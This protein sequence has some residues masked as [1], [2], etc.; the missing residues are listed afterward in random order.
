MS[1]GR[2]DEALAAANRGLDIDRELGRDREVAAGLG[3]C[4]Q[5]L[6]QQGRHA[7]A[8]AQYDEAIAATRRAGDKDLE[9][10][11][12][13]HQGILADD[14]RQYA[15]AASLYERA[16]KLFQEMNAEDGVMRTCNSLGV[17]E[18]NQGRLPEARSWY[19]RSREIAQRLGDI[20]C[21]AQAAQNIGIVCQQ[22]GEAARQQGREREARQRF[23]EAKG[24]IAESLALE[25]QRDNAPAAAE[26]LGQLAQVHLLLGELDEAERHAQQAREIFERLGLKETHMIYAVLANIARA[27]GDA[28]QAAEWDRKRDA[29]LEELDRRSRGSGGLPPQFFAAVQQLAVA[30]AQAS[31]DSA[32]LAPDVESALAQLNQLSAPLPELSAF[33]R[34]VAAGQFPPVPAALPPEL[35]Q[36]LT[37]LQSALREARPTA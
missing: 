29:V 3:Q 20:T 32:E 26:S 8:D 31:V 17:V 12:L 15:R 4:A 7:E 23:E 11:L 1:A 13:Q 25:R 16:L 22:E 6:M 18:Q 33:L 19:Q 21:L 30:C 35:A 14:L 36:F 9:G 10:T 27:R 24:F 28:A 37:Q 5:I 2:L 34:A